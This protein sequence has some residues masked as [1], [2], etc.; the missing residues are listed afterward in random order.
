VPG[1]RDPRELDVLW[2][3]GLSAVHV[4]GSARPEY[5]LLIRGFFANSRRLVSDLLDETTGVLAANED[6]ERVVQVLSE[7]RAGPAPIRPP[8]VRGSGREA[9]PGFDRLRG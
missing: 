7:E 5:A 3:V 8:R 4:F 6:L 1:V 2:S 9:K